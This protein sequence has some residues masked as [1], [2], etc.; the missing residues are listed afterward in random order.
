MVG[1]HGRA[2]RLPHKVETE[3][4]WENWVLQSPS[5]AHPNDL[6]PPMRPHLSQIYS[7]SL[8][9]KLLTHELLGDIQHPNY[10][11]SFCWIL[12]QGPWVFHLWSLILD[13]NVQS[14]GSWGLKRAWQVTEEESGFSPQRK[15]PIHAAH[16]RDWPSA[17]GMLSWFYTTPL[18][19]WHQLCLTGD[20]R[21][22]L[23][24][25]TSHIPEIGWGLG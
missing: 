17:Q 16:Y 22:K 14:S 1:I 2:N 20:G 11:T 3:R 24:P 18:S 15:T 7:N 21:G 10:S 4:D 19:S 9:T 5:R 12:S 6:R 13:S 25:S 23:E 8:K